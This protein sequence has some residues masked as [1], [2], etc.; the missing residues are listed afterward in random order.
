MS[1]PPLEVAMAGDTL[2]ADGLAIAY[3]SMTNVATPRLSRAYVL[4]GTGTPTFTAPQGTVYIN[5]TGSGIANRMFINTTGSTTWTS[6]TT[7]A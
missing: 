6:V 7:A 4:A 3:D 2:H 5:L 1:L